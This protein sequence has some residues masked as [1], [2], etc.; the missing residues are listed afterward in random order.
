MDGRAARRRYVRRIRWERDHDGGRRERLIATTP[1]ARGCRMRARR[2]IAGPETGRQ[3]GDAAAAVRWSDRSAPDTKPE[4][5]R[6]PKE[7]PLDRLTSLGM[8]EESAVD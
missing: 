1:D 2:G 7:R 5:G 3:I 4:D 8:G 6:M